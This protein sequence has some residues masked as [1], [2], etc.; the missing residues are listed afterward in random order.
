MTFSVFQLELKEKKEKYA[1]TTK[2]TPPP[3]PTPL[4]NWKKKAQNQSIWD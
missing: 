4:Q 2:K 1:H 3:H